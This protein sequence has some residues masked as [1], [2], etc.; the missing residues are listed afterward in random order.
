MVANVC[1]KEVGRRENY[2]RIGNSDGA[3]DGR[4]AITPIALAGSS[5][6]A[7]IAYEVYENGWDWLYENWWESAIIEALVIAG[8]FDATPVGWIITAAD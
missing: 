1:C 7:Y 5:N 2:S 8:D 3:G 4:M 6:L